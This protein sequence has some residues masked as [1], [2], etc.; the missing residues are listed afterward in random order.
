[1]QV[2]Q[3]SFVTHRLVIREYTKYDIDDFARV[4]GQ[5]QIYATTVGIP[6]NYTR[7][8]AKE[9]LKFIEKSRKNFSSLEYGIF[10]KSDSRYI[11]N[12]GLINIDTFN[13]RA[14]ISYYID[15]N[16]WGMGFAE[17]AARKMLYLGFEVYGFNRI[18]G[19]CMTCNPASRRVMEKIGMKYEGCDRQALLKDGIYYDLDR[20][21]ILNEEY[22][23]ESKG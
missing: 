14:D 10:L 17:E 23:T 11:G 15:Y 6:R 18:G 7:R 1:M 9:W 16:F 4:T 8:H 2:Q 12:V 22:F 5:P 13:N 21:S 3:K 19:I 20:L